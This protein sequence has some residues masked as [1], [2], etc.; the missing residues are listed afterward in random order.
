VGA[1]EDLLSE[2]VVNGEAYYDADANDPLQALAP[3][4]GYVAREGS[5]GPFGYD[6]WYE[7]VRRFVEAVRRAKDGT[8]GGTDGSSGDTLLNDY[9]DGLLSLGP[10][11]AG[12]ESARRGEQTFYC[13]CSAVLLISAS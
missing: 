10:V 9:A 12:W 7:Q 8:T 1:A 2:Q 6:P 3:R 13:L 4:D 5:S 11:L